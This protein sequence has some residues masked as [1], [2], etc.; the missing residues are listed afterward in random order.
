MTEPLV[1][2]DWFRDIY[3]PTRLPQDEVAERHA[4]I[5]G[6]MAA[7]EQ[8]RPA[9]RWISVTKGLP[10]I[11]T[12]PYA[13]YLVWGHSPIGPVRS[14]VQQVIQF[15]RDTGRFLTFI[16]FGQVLVI[17]HLRDK[18]EPPVPRFGPPDPTQTPLTGEL[19]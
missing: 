13:S 18:P 9:A 8:W 3:M 19:L 16:S 7:H 4:A 17:S 10:P 1:F 15:S 6:W 11:P 5:A 12:T 2:D 14:G